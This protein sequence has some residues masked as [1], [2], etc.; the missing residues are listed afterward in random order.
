MNNE[1]WKD[2]FKAEYLMF[3]ESILTPERTN[4]EVEQIIKLV[5]AETSLNILDL[6]CGQGRIAVP[7]A[8][9][10]MKVTG[11]DQSIDLL[12]EAARRA[13]IVGTNLSLKQLDF[14]D[15]CDVEDYDVILNLGTALGYSPDEVEDEEV[16]HLAAR[17]LKTGGYLIIDTENRENKVKQAPDRTWYNM[18]NQLVLSERNFDYITGRWKEIISWTESGAEKRAELNLRLY[19]IPEWIRM[20]KLAGL[21]IRGVY[22]GFDL[23]SPTA[24]SPRLVLVAQKP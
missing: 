3:S 21:D 10:G 14:R 4:Y 15:L 18:N 24:Q 11:Y 9:K 22:G 2:F 23:N 19:T 8:Q 12:N 5:Q 16:I 6:G 7:L 20:I 1:E 17:A 13:S